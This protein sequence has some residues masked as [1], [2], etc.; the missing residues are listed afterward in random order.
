MLVLARRSNETIQ[1]G[2]D[3]TVT[4]LEIKG[5]QVRLGIEAPGDVVI[6]REEL[7]EVE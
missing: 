3:I 2:D 5:N 4:L 7:L 6:L 1:I